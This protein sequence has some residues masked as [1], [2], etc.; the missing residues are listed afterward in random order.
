M[1]NRPLAGLRVLELARILA[2]PWAGQMLADLGA[3]VIKV[4]SPTGDDTRR[5]GPPFIGETAAY[6]H[7]TNR[8]KRAMVAD[9][10]TPEGKALVIDLARNADVMIENFK[11]GGLAAYGLDHASLA[12]I[13]PRL[14]TCSIT[15]FGQSGPD[16]ARPGYDYVMQGLSGLMSVTGEP[17]GAPQKVGVAVIDVMTGTYACSAIL[18]ALHGRA[19]SG[20][21]CH[22]D[23][24]LLDV[25]LA[26]MA[27]QA[28]NALVGEKD[29]GRLG[30]A[31][32]NLAPYQVMQAADGHIILAVGNDLQFASLCALIGRP[33]LAH[34]PDFATN[35][36][37]V[38]N[39]T[40][41]AGLI[42]AYT[43]NR[44]VAALLE[45]C[46][47]R[48]IP[49]APIHSMREALDQEQAR[50]RDIASTTEG[51]PTVRSPFRFDGQAVPLGSKSPD[52]G[53][54][55]LTWIAGKQN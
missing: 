6:F 35:A 49:A 32:P 43:G 17:E 15:G 33:E 44:E 27:N 20:K 1:S 22:I 4:E 47:S 14:I 52:L 23:M 3:D 13:N 9:F 16:A 41:L 19:S 2:G 55:P 8:G 42:E 37:R 46:R 54:V 48:G 38:T 29:P 50:F 7:A 18:A 12:A 24:A 31:H 39:R 21:G 34:D 45:D 28:M 51:V 30:N 11:T 25:G 10:A 5:W 26:M 36:A 40:S 53:Q